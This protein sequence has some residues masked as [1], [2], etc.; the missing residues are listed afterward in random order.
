MTADPI[1]V[2]IDELV[3]M[4]HA[5]ASNRELWRRQFDL[6]LAW[7]DFDEGCGGLALE[8]AARNRVWTR[9]ARAGIAHP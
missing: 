2:A 9:L 8:R 5:G 1:E 4:Q 3:A 6:G 7:P